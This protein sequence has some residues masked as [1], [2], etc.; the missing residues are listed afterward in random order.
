MPRSAASS[1]RLGFEENIH[2]LQATHGRQLQF[3][4]PCAHGG[5]GERMHDDDHVDVSL[6]AF[7]M[8]HEI[9]LTGRLELDDYT[10]AAG[11]QLLSKLQVYRPDEKDVRD[12]LT[13]LKDLELAQD[14]APGVIGLA[15]IAELCA[16]DWGL[17][18]DVERNLG[19]AAALV[20]G[21]ALSSDEERRV[22]DALARVR[23]AIEDAPKSRRWRWRAQVGE[24]LPGTTTSRTKARTSTGRGL[25]SDADVLRHRP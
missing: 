19:R 17:H 3:V 8:D 15:H 4:R 5:D 12:V 24:R 14:D 13:L 1:A 18:H 20:T 21:Y 6:D 25:P 10:I 16:D 22:R 23:R 11:D 2:F 9:D 7:K